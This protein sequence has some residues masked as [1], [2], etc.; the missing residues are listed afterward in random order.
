MQTERQQL[1]AFADVASYWQG[2]FADTPPV[3]ELPT[4]QTRPP[5]KTY[6]ASQAHVTFSKSLYND[7]KQC[8]AR[9]GATLYVTL[10][11]GF[12]TLLHCLRIWSKTSF[13]FHVHSGT[14]R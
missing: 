12:A 14:A 1:P 13:C 10:L 2:Q 4:D 3:L 7:L 6:P 8:S 9:Q 11:M 5:L